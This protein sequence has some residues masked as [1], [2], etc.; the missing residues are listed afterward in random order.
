MPHLSTAG[1]VR[2]IRRPS[3]RL[4]VTA[5]VTPH[6]LLLTGAGWPAS[7][8]PLAEALAEMGVALPAGDAT[9]PPCC[10]VNLPLRTTA[11]CVALLKV[12]ATAR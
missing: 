6:H 8:G 9:T 11:D 2:L 5:E 7:T 12:C 1:A 3:A 4:P 10:K